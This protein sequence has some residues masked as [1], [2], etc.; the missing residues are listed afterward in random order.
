MTMNNTWL[1]VSKA[2]TRYVNST[3]VGM[4]LLCIRFRSV[5]IVNVTY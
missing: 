2:L 1:E 4:F 3:H 5:L